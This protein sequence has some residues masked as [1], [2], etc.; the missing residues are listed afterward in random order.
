MP[1]RMRGPGSNQLSDKDYVMNVVPA[2]RMSNPAVPARVGAAALWLSVLLG[3]TAPAFSQ[4]ATVDGIVAVV[5]GKQVRESDIRL[6]DEIVGRNLPTQ[7][8][9]DRREALLKMLID[10]IL[11]AQVAND[12]KIVDEADIERRISFARNQGMMNH[13]LAVVGQQAV[14]EQSIRETYDELVVK[15]AKNEPELHLRHLF[16]MIK[17]PRD[18][19][20]AKEAEEKASA[21]AKRIKNGEDFAA[22]AAEVSED[23]AT[24]A[25]GGDFDWRSRSEMGKEYADVAFTLKNGEV[26]SPFKTAVA[27][28]IIKL[29]DQ[30]PRKPMPL[31]KIK[32]RIAAMVAAKTQ[33]ELV[34]KA[35]EAAKIERM[36][37]PGSSQKEAPK[38]N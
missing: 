2:F 35:R 7:D 15:A 8:K 29:E 38:E 4:G 32:D 37:T 24:K 22:V 18:D 10:T 13:L 33:F 12:R 34:D 27:W 11:L 21:A 9:V 28:H 19:A 17:D 26:S 3:A 30:R 5:N 25:R 31:D 6:V 20:A 36:D 23:P 16:F 1:T 14:T